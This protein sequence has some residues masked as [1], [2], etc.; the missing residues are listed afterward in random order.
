MYQ[1]IDE[2]ILDLIITSPTNPHVTDV[3]VDDMGFPHHFVVISTIASERPESV[4]QTRKTRNFKV[5]DLHAFLLK[6][7]QSVVYT[8]KDSFANQFRNCVVDVLDELVPLRW[9]TK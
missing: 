8:A 6:L 1:H 9:M 7:W 4:F 5:M 2:G 3:H